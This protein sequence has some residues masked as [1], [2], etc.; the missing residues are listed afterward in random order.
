[1]TLAVRRFKPTPCIDY[2]LNVS[3]KLK[4]GLR[5]TAVTWM[6]IHARQAQTV[7]DVRLATLD[8]MQNTIKDRFKASSP[9]KFY[10]SSLSAVVQSLLILRPSVE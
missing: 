2:T 6:D 8:G 1:M 3:H 10:A 4:T 7:T 5:F 9:L